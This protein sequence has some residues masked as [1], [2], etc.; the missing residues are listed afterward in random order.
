MAFDIF[1]LPGTAQRGGGSTASKAGA[2]KTLPQNL[3]NYEIMDRINVSFVFAI[4][5]ESPR[6]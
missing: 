4:F 5:G 2:L 1:D 3:G 6:L